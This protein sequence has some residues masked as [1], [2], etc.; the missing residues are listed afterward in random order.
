MGEGW[1][2]KVLTP[3]KGGLKNFRLQERGVRKVYALFQ[4]PK[5]QILRASSQ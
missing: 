4:N 5:S 1:G 2:K 3:E